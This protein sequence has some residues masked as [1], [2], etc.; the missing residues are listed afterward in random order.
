MRAVWL[1][2]RALI[3]TDG[4]TSYER[5]QAEHGRFRGETAIEHHEH[6]PGEPILGLRM[7]YGS[8][9]A[10]PLTSACIPQA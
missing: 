9:D 5:C 6:V 3:H 7:Y 8:G 2:N 4:K 1:A 10:H